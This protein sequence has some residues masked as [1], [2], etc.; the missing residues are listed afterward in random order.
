[1]E[2]GFSA[3]EQA[4]RN[5][6]REWLRKELPS[7]WFGFTREEQFHGEGWKWSKTMSKKLAANGWLTMAWPKEYGGQGRPA[8]EQ[9][10]FQ[11]EVS[12]HGVPGYGMGIGGVQWVGPTLM[13]YGSEEQKKEH[14]PKIAA[15]D[16]W[17][18]TGY[19][20]PETG[21][22]LASL[23]TRAVRDGDDYVINGQK[24]WTSS[25]HIA[26]W[27]WLAARTDPNAPP[28]KGI[29]VFLMN[30]K[31]PGVRVRVIKNMPNLDYFNEVF[32][33]EVR[34][35]ARNRVGEENQGWYIV[36]VALDFERGGLTHYGEAKRALDK[37]CAFV[38]EAGHNGR[39][40]SV[41]PVTRNRLGE[42]ALEV[43]VQRLLAYRVAWLQGKGLVP[44]Y[45][46][47]VSKI[48][49][50]ELKQRI[51]RTG[52]EIMGQYSQLEFEERM[53]PMGGMLE[54][55]YLATI[56]DTIMAGTSEVQRNIIATRG[57]GLPRA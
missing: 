9:A 13:L 21:S 19:S 33:D 5:E 22:D 34:I 3:Q 25:A 30:M 42:I 50:T 17:W 39:G 36:A 18:C 4:F 15:A 7:D 51:A 10:V 6:I 8:I 43:E 12:Y 16:T 40:V 31:S 27:C 46:A 1:M 32:L 47:S 57:L 14:L 23:K 52:L 55:M 48:F 54:R 29:S 2:F 56:G 44:N 24:I 20:E 37:L 26:D 28:H 38:K 41:T 53:A 35:P 11:E 45:Q 49:V